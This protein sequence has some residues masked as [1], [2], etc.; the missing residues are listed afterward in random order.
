MPSSIQENINLR[1][2]FKVHHQQYEQYLHAI[3]TGK[4]SSQECIYYSH[5]QFDINFGTIFEQFFSVIATVEKKSSKIKTSSAHIANTKKDN[6]RIIYSFLHYDNRFNP[7]YS[8]FIG[9]KKEMFEFL[10][11]PPIH[12][13]SAKIKSAIGFFEL[14]KSLIIRENKTTK[15]KI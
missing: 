14:D 7:V 6:Y 1:D 13:C 9:T 5:S 10:E 4:T 11:E 8:E 12:F 3:E 2:L 15:L